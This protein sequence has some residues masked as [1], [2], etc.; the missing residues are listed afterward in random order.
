M[1]VN[2][3]DVLSWDEAYAKADK[4]V[5]QLTLDQFVSI[6]Q[7]KG[8][9]LGKCTGVS[10][11]TTDPDLPGLC[12]SDGPLGVRASPYASVFP[13]GINAAA[14]FDKEAIHQRGLDMGA[15]FR[16]KGAN[17]QLGP[18]MNIARVPNAGR[19]WE[20]F[21]EVCIGKR[22]LCSVEVTNKSFFLLFVNKDP[23]LSGVAAFETIKAVQ[24]QGVVSI[25]YS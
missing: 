19:N 3:I 1:S 15:E 18:A 12:L 5:S 4:L 20:G 7:G 21:E 9:L 6:S 8:L 2:S 11:S 14:S 23:Y 16:G 25:A 22:H 13:A 10:G 24:S 17:V